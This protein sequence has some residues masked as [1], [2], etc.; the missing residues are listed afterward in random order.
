MPKAKG[1][2]GWAAAE[3]RMRTKE[4][5]YARSVRGQTSAK[6]RRFRQNLPCFVGMGL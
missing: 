4:R 3:V 2:K 5:Y 6:E 1:T